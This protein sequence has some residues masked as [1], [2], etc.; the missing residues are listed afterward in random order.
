MARQPQ[1][2]SD[3]QARRAQLLEETLDR[4]RSRLLRQA[5]RHSRRP[6]DAEDAL[7][8][9]SVQFLRFY[10]TGSSRDPLPWMLLV[11]K[12]CAWAITRRTK[13][14]E[15]RRRL[16]DGEW[17]DDELAIVL[18][19]ERAGP[20]ERAESVEET[21]EVIALIEELKP[22]ERTA[23]I[24]LGLGCTYKEIAALRGW[25]ATKVNRCIFEGKARVRQRLR[26]GGK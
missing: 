1:S 4:E 23:L 10:D 17:I 12:R 6:E 22:D 21:A 25:S 11:V 20:F 14:R 7:A 19:D 16:S 24:L 15:S 13:G 9:A 8:D 2:R 3:E 5:Q 26:G 18:A